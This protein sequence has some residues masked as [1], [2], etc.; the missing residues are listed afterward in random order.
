[1]S[2]GIRDSGP[3]TDGLSQATVLN[4]RTGVDQVVIVPDECLALRAL[5]LHFEA[6]GTE[7]IL[8]RAPVAGQG[9]QGAGGRK[10]IC[11]GFSHSSTSMFP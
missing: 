8:I 3:E 6:D 7:D 9:Q 1:M 4:G 11:K 10:A 2:C 5:L